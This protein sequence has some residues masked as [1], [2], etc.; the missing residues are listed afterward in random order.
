MK[1]WSR[2]CR[3]PQ[4]FERHGLRSVTLG[5]EHDRQTRGPV[6][7]PSSPRPQTI[8]RRW[9]RAL[10]LSHVGVLM[11]SLGAATLYSSALGAAMGDTITTRYNACG[12]GSCS[13]DGWSSA[14]PARRTIPH[15]ALAKGGVSSVFRVDNLETEIARLRRI[16][17][18]ARNRLCLQRPACGLHIARRHLIELLGLSRRALSVRGPHARQPGARVAAHIRPPN[19]PL[20]LVDPA[21]APAPRRWFQCLLA[22]VE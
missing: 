8:Y 4:A 15:T 14:D 22:R 5:V 19:G 16:V 6:T 3:T 11:P 13:F 21:G 1:T 2:P 12:C 10:R 9:L 7:E 17:P 18:P 20:V